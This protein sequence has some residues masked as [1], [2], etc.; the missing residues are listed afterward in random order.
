M[1]PGYSRVSEKPRIVV[2]QRDIGAGVRERERMLSV[3]WRPMVHP[4]VRRVD[5]RCK[6][7]SR[8]RQRGP[9]EVGRAET[10]RYDL[11]KFDLSFLELDL[12][13]G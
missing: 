3:G 1:S 8:L 10:S 11:R 4:G 2:C 6:T 13:V 5:P 9:V 12:S 7:R